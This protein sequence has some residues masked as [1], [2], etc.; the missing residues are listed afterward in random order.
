MIQTKLVRRHFT[1]EDLQIIVI[2]KTLDFVGFLAEP[3][4]AALA[5]YSS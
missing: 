2:S 1:V 3:F 5:V 4:D